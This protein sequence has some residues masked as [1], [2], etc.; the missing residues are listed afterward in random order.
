MALLWVL[1]ARVEKVRRVKTST[2]L[3]TLPRERVCWG[4]SIFQ[5]MAARCIIATG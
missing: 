5:P 1:R 4:L 2:G 3:A